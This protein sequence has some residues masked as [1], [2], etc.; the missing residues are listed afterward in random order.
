MTSRL[1][2]DASPSTTVIVRELSTE[3]RYLRRLMELGL[4]PG[5]HATVLQRTAGG[6]RV[7]EINGARIALDRSM[8]RAI[9]IDEL[10]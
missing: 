1:L 2:A 7:V 5:A 9:A 3:H 10:A 4:R 6:G 8:T